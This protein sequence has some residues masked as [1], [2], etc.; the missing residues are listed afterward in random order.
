MLSGA[1]LRLW[2]FRTLGRFFTFDLSVKHDH[3]LVTAGPYS[4]VRH[5]SYVGSALMAS[6]SILVLLGPGSW[7]R[8]S[9]V[10]GTAVG[11]VVA[12]MWVAYSGVLV[13]SLWG[14]VNKEDEVLRERFGSEWDLY[15][16]TTRYRLIPFV[17]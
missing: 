10:L 13:C 16:S 6:G 17:H 4:V 8:G 5:P 9:G 14:R 1:S 3:Q 7:A 11:K 12:T 15:A 2:C